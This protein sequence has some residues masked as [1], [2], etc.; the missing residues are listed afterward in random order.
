MK[1]Q[2]PAT[3][4][5]ISTLADGSIRIVIDSQEMPP[6]QMA[7]L[8]E[9]RNK[10]GWMMFAENEL[11][12]SDIPE[13]QAEVDEESPSSRLRKTIAVYCNKKYGSYDKTSELYR[14][15]MSRLQQKYLELIDDV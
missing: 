13:Q 6:E 1:L 10:L 9:L 4:G 3:I 12:E 11:Q 15:A 5:K 8:F 2:L 7:I 14:Q